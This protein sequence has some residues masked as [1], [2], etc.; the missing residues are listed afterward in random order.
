MTTK[1]ENLWLAVS[2]LLFLFYM[3]IGSFITT[4]NIIDLLIILTLVCYLIQYA[5]IK[6]KDKNK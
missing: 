4:G 6:T 5:I 2:S 1:Q 3:L